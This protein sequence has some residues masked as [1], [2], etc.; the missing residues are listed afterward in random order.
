MIILDEIIS[1]KLKNEKY[2]LTESQN[3]QIDRIVEGIMD[4]VKKMFGGE[5]ASPKSTGTGVPKG[6]GKEDVSDELAT[7]A[8][9]DISGAEDAIQGDA[10]AQKGIKK[11][12]GVWGTLKKKGILGGYFTLLQKLMKGYMTVLFGTGAFENEQQAVA[13]AQELTKTAETEGPE[14]VV[15]D[16]AKDLSGAGKQ[17]DQSSDE[18]EQNAADDAEA[19][20]QDLID[21]SDDLPDESGEAGEA[22]VSGEGPVPLFKGKDGGLYSK[23]YSSLL[24]R[25]GNMSKDPNSMIT[26]AKINK[27]MVKDTVK[28]I[29]KDL[30][31]QLRANNLKVTESWKKDVIALAEVTTAVQILS[32]AA[33]NPKAVTAD[34]FGDD[35]DPYQRGG[36]QTQIP[37][38]TGAGRVKPTKGQVEA[39]RA[40]GGKVQDLIMRLGGGE[41][42]D[43][44]DDPELRTMVQKNSQKLVTTIITKIVKPYLAPYLKKAGIKMKE[45]QQRAFENELIKI[46]MEGIDQTIV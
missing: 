42:E 12:L 19:L 13:K 2:V 37:T 22:P 14:G 4:N 24:G 30:S 36:L 29:L 41:R 15:K 3:Q 28:Q 34:D 17:G 11:G 20:S 18:D 38:K 16:M 10:E 8:N 33:K 45:N 39:G 23:L 46:I 35:M 44:Y 6:P 1:Q 7:V 25:L 43:M 27:A 31:A 32:E 9:S 40:V 5:K 21:V 26:N